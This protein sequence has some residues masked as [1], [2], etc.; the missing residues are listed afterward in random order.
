MSKHTPGP[1]T[2]E[3]NHLD[4]IRIVAANGI[5]ICNMPHWKGVRRTELVAN[6]EKIA[7]APELL[8][9]CKA[10]IE[11]FGIMS[12]GCIKMGG[13]AIAKAEGRTQT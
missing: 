13:D 5:V 4:Y 6:A 1:W 10:L 3:C 12:D 8:E 11:R 2:I 9:A 7:A